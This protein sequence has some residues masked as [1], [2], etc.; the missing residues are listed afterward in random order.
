MIVREL[1]TE[2]FRHTK[3]FPSAYGRKPSTRR[4]QIEIVPSPSLEA[5]PG[6]AGPLLDRT[7]G[8]DEVL[9]VLRSRGAIREPIANC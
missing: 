7:Y 9:E 6:A 8:L 2:T 3:D 1:R 4:E 5:L